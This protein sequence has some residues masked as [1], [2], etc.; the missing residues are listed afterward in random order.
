M[1][2][3]VKVLNGRVDTVN[4]Y[5]EDGNPA[6]GGASG[7]GISIEF[8]NGPLGRGD[9]RTAPNGAVVEDLLAIV[10]ER[11]RFYQRPGSRPA[12]MP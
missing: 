3:D 9:D 10:A 11:M 4:V 1:R 5:D 12:R 2:S 7:I 6:G 8:Q